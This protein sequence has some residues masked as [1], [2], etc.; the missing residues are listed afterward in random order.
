MHTS[1]TQ[2]LLFWPKRPPSAFLVAETSVAEMSEHPNR[3]LS[4]RQIV[5]E[6]LENLLY[7]GPDK[8]TRF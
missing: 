3:D 8:Q 5:L 2:N 7:I 1:Q 6:I 4:D